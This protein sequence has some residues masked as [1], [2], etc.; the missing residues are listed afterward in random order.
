MSLDKKKVLVGFS[1]GVDSTASV[2]LLQQQGYEVTGIFFNVF[3]KITETQKRAIEV[4]NQ[5]NISLIIED[6]SSYFKEKIMDYFFYE[7]TMGRTPN[8]CVHC[9][10]YVKFSLMLQ[11]AQKINAYY[12][13][14]GH[15]AIIQYDEASK[16]YII[17]KPT[18]LNKDQTY[19]LYNLDQ[20]ILKHVLFPLGNMASKDDVR[21]I[22]RAAGLANAETKDSQEICFIENND[23][24]SFITENYDYKSLEGDFVNDKGDIL[25]KHQG[26]IHYTIG[27]R[28]G[29][30]IALGKPAYVTH[31]NKE[32]NTVTLGE[33]ENLFSKIVFSHNN[34][35][36][37]DIPVEPIEVESKIRYSAKPAKAMI[38]IENNS[39]V[40]TTFDKPQRAITPGQSIVFYSKDVLLGGGII[41]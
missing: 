5:L 11:N 34:H 1:G 36:I 22:A 6:I 30:G 39:I 31:I 7:Y 38:S 4:A 40:K 3:G 25:G 23:Y 33:N 10:K 2:L 24:V 12:I 37:G 14:T 28:K 21:D 35:F 32:K 41:I 17:R 15:Y 20:T 8:P 16:S 26:I 18:A 27:Q 13:A 9:N 29:L 19:M